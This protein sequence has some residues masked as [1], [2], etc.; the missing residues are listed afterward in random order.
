MRCTMRYPAKYTAGLGFLLPKMGGPNCFAL[1]NKGG[2]DWDT[3]GDVFYFF[4]D[5]NRRF[6]RGDGGSMRG[7]HLLWLTSSAEVL[8]IAIKN[9]ISDSR[10][11]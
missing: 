1:S 8:M 5:Q 11:I 7:P 9:L 3:I 2:F 4:C 6:L 10:E